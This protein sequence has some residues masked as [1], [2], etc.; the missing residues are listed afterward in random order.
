MR[1]AAALLLATA[2]GLGAA[3]GARAQDGGAGAVPLAAQAEGAPISRIDVVLARSGGNPVRENAAVER[4]RFSLAALEGRGFSR[5]LI[6]RELALAR[7]RFG[8]GRID[9]RLGPGTTPGTLGLI[10]EIDAAGPVAG[11]PPAPTGVF[12]GDP[13][14]FP[15]LFRSDRAVLTAIVTGGF[16]AYA[17][18]NPWFGRPQGFIGNS[19]LAGRLPGS[20]PVWTEGFTEIG[21]A[22][23]TQV[24]DTPF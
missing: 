20:A 6:E 17:D 24:G 14:R 23:A 22:G 21:L 9:Y 15:D 2:A 3:P 19:P 12:A 10:V 4:L 18:Q 11:A 16:G 13:A 7:G 8:T 5:G 1:A